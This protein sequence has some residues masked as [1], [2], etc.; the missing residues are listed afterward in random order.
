MTPP[1]QPESE[2]QK[3][4][5][6]ISAWFEHILEVLKIHHAATGAPIPLLPAPPTTTPASVP[7][8]PPAVVP[9]PEEALA[10]GQTAIQNLGFYEGFKTM[11]PDALAAW[12]VAFL[13]QPNAAVP[14]RTVSHA[15][16]HYQ[17][18]EYAVTDTAQTILVQLNNNSGTPFPTA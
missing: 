15:I 7:N 11:T 3:I 2:L 9:T 18:V 14:D 1:V 16:V 17:G 6:N 12:I 10:L 4:E 13:T 5:H 8:L